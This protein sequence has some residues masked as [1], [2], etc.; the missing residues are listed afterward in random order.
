[1]DAQKKGNGEWGNGELESN[2]LPPPSLGVWFDINLKGSELNVCF[3]GLI[4]IWKVQNL[5][6]CLLFG[7]TVF[8]V[9]GLFATNIGNNHPY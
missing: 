8:K 4:L 1:M 3:F 7:L 9:H 2:S 5:T 6:E